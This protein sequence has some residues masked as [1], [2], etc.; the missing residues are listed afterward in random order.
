MADSLPATVPAPVPPDA[1][2][3]W[4]APRVRDQYAVDRSVVATISE[5]PDG[6]FA[7]RS[8]EPPV[9]AAS[10]RVL[11]QVREHLADVPVDRPRTRAGTVE[12]MA[13]GLPPAYRRVVRR[14]ADPTPSQ[15]RRLEYHLGTALAGLDELTPL[16][17]DERI[18]VADT[19]G[20]TLLVHTDD[21]APVE[22][23]LSTDAPFLDRFLSERLAS[24]E[25]SV[26]GREVPVTVARE[27][28]L[29][30]D[31]FTTKYHVRSPVRLPGDD[32]VVTATER[33]LVGSSVGGRVADPVAHVRRRARRHVRRQL[34]AG[35][36]RTLLA[37]AGRGVRS[38]AAR[39]GLGE[40][41]VR[42]TPEDR[43]E[44]LTAVVLR[45]LVGEGPL[46]VPLRDPHLERVE[47]NRVGERV[48]V[49]AKPGAFED[50]GR[51]PSTIAI[52]DERRFVSLATRLAATGGVELGPRRPTATVTIDPAGDPVRCSVALPGDDGPYIAIDKRG[53]EPVTP[54]EA[55]GSGAATAA[56][57]ALAWLVIERR[58]SVL[59]LG[60]ERARPADLVEA[61]A[62]FIPYA[63]RPVTVAG[64]TRS[65]SVPHETGV[66]LAP[67]RD[68]AAAASRAAALAP[69]FAVLTDLADPDSEALFADAVTAGRGV[70]AASRV[71]DFETFAHR[72]L[73][74]DV[75]ANALAAI[76]LVVAVTEADGERSVATVLRPSRDG[77]RAVLDAPDASLDVDELGAREPDVDPVVSALAAEG[78]AS[79]T[80]LRADYERRVRYVRYLVDREL[81]DVEDLFSLLADLRTDE[82][83]TLERISRVMTA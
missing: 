6:G 62:P 13:E 19:G 60:P 31:A 1:A 30:G 3:A 72:A 24:Y 28:L 14:F 76:D 4:Y 37:R 66:E 75:P 73:E 23:G 35:S 54:A 65:V 12:R 39:V 63:D 58:G 38:L 7:Y 45:D 18:R 80:E 16:A 79:E 57:V 29:G 26:L 41:P 67:D 48:K 10:E 50:A 81:T 77:D 82:A 69:D 17:L 2:D 52:D 42:R 21:F 78:Q 56:V 59:F 43:V 71:R 83:A 20:E 9:G 44:A 15:N 61:H 74:R 25:V 70:L 36:A 33:A 22:T 46:S 55:V 53:Q 34:L 27:R 8:R 40:P 47:T 32:A 68:G 11:E 51:M 64:G 5:T 49:V